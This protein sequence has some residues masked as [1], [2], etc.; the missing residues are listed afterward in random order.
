M[1]LKRG[2]GD[3]LRNLLERPGVAVR[4]SEEGVL[5]SAEISD[6]ADLD[7]SPGELSASGR[8]V[9]HDEV[10]VLDARSSTGI[11]HPGPEH[12]RAR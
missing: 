5:D 11:A 9:G 1:L 3:V 8:Y 7:P 12:D 2:G 10:K 4:I 6:L